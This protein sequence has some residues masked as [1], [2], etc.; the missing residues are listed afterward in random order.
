M[1]LY[2]DDLFLI[3]LKKLLGMCKE[4][5]VSKFEMEDI[6]LIQYFLGLEVS[7]QPREIFLMQG[8]YVVE[9]LKRFRMEDYKIMSTPVIT[10]LSKLNASGSKLVDPTLYRQ[11]IGS[12]MYLVN[13]RLYICFV[14][15]TLGQFKLYGEA[16]E[17]SLGGSE[18]CVQ[19]SP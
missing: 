11:L 15:N 8:D 14:V 16:E 17:G 18:A 3:G 19:V 13:T 6:G 5:L 4:D 12:L 1:V 2:V 7:Q 9:I 10:N